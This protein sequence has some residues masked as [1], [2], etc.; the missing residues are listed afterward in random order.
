MTSTTG[1][2]QE[3]YT[4][5]WRLQNQLLLLEKTYISVFFDKFICK[6]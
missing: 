1:K 6:S 5:L 2:F 3:I 4:S